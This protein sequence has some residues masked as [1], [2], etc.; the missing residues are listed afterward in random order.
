MT[1]SNHEA[2]AV[3]I[4]RKRKVRWTFF[5]RSI[6]SNG[7]ALSLREVDRPW[8]CAPRWRVGSKSSAQRGKVRHDVVTMVRQRMLAVALGHEDLNDH[9]ALRR[10]QTP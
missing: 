1:E 2:F 6:S 3:S 9:D 5:G 7:G 8:A 10:D 4:R